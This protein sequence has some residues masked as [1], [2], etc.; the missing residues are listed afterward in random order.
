MT[1]ENR[2][3]Y[4]M[5]QEKTGE[6]YG[7]LF[8]SYNKKLF[9]ESPS[10]ISRL[11]LHANRLQFKDPTRNVEHSFEAPLPKDFSAV[12]KTFRKW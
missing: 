11:T 8:T 4:R 3:A 2:D 5:Y 9:S 6:I 10:L 12:V 7:S 1:K